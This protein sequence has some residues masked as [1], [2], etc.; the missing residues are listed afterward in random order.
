MWSSREK[1]KLQAASLLLDW[2]LEKLDL[3]SAY[4]GQFKKHQTL[5]VPVSLTRRDVGLA[6]L[7]AVPLFMGTDTLWL[8]GSPFIALRDEGL[9]PYDG[10]KNG[11]SWSWIGWYQIIQPENQL[12]LADWLDSAFGVRYWLPEESLVERETSRWSLFSSY[13]TWTAWV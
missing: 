4:F 13:S 11:W 12:T 1:F 6:V 10:V 7:E 5:L 9:I 2:L 3:N 8:A